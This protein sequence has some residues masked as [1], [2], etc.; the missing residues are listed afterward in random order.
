MTIKELRNDYHVFRKLAPQKVK[1]ALGVSALSIAELIGSGV[2]AYTYNLD[3]NNATINQ[4][5]EIGFG[6]FIGSM[7]Y[8]SAY[9]SGRIDEREENKQREKVCSLENK[10]K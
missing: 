1:I 3:F 9:L 4:L 7:I 5:Y 6:C 2:F 10:C 8:T